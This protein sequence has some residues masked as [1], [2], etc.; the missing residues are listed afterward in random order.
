MGRKGPS[1]FLCPKQENFELLSALS[2]PQAA[3]LIHSHTLA[4]LPDKTL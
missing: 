4:P 1:P 3:L 2:F